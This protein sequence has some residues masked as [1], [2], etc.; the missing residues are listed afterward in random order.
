MKSY[1]QMSFISGILVVVCYLG[2]AFLAY[3]KCPL[4]L[5]FCQLYWLEWVTVGLFLAY[6]GLFGF[7]T[8]S[9]Q[10]SFVTVAHS[11]VS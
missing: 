7:N 2:L 8:K 1:R 6:T 4:S 11:K 5:I 10:T 9:L 3:T